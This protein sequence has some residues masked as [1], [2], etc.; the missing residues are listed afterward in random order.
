MFL[1]TLSLYCKGS[2]FIR[3]CLQLN[4]FHFSYSHL[5]FFDFSMMQEFNFIG[6]SKLYCT[7]CKSIWSYNNTNIS[8]IKVH[9]SSNL[10]NSTITN[11]FR[12]KFALCNKLIS[13]FRSNNIYPLL[14]RRLSCLC[15]P[16]I[17][18]KLFSAE[19]FILIWRHF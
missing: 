8:F 4:G 16:S 14:R 6:F 12:I 9:S 13:S 19:N 3:K 10:L 7:F 15:L 18:F 11:S 1:L 17:F 2:K 5:N